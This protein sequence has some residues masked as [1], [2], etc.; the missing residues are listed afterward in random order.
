MNYKW[1]KGNEVTQM[2]IHSFTSISFL[3]T[4]HPIVSQTSPTQRISLVHG[5][6][7]RPR[8]HER[9]RSGISKMHQPFIPSPPTPAAST[10]PLTPTST[11]TAPTSNLVAAAAAAAAATAYRRKGGY[12]DETSLL[13]PVLHVA[14]VAARLRLA[15]LPTSPLQLVVLLVTDHSTF[16]TTTNGTLALLIGHDAM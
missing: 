16:R 9:P 4:P 7:P 10:L 5:P 3:P 6:A 15:R 11:T 8:L 14:H 13:R 2:F 12:M 1:P